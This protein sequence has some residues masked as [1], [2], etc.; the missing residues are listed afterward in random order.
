MPSLGVVEALEIEF[1]AF[2]VIRKWRPWGVLRV[3][4]LDSNQTLPVFGDCAVDIAVPG[5]QLAEK[6]VQRAGIRMNCTGRVGLEAQG[7]PDFIL[8]AR[9]VALPVKPRC[10]IPVPLDRFGVAF[11]IAPADSHVVVPEGL[12]PP[13]SDGIDDQ[14]GRRSTD[15]QAPSKDVLTGNH[16]N[17]IA[18]QDAP[19]DRRQEQIVVLNQVRHLVQHHHGRER[20]SHPCCAEEMEPTPRD[21][22][23][24][25]QGTAVT[26]NTT[27]ASGTQNSGDDGLE[28]GST[29]WLGSVRH[30]IANMVR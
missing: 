23:T 7:G 24:Q 26:T 1:D 14:H 15:H 28:T 17:Q 20:N 29:R 12:H 4:I 16:R 5:Q 18:Q 6:M 9:Q 30:G 3:L 21:R 27:A 13:Q 8:G 2:C 25:R 19:S 11:N 22:A 10:Q